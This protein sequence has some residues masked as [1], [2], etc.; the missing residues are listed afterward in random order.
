[1]IWQNNLTYN[2][3]PGKSAV[4]FHRAKLAAG[5]LFGRD[6]LLVEPSA[7]FRLKPG[8]PAIGAG[9]SDHGVP[10]V[11]LEGNPR[12]GPVDIGAYAAGAP[13]HAAR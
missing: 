6:P 3:T 8:S 11:D 9:T 2:G 5:N 7:D 1:M 12:K 4:N 10:E 13:K